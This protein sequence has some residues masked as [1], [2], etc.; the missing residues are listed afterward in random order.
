VTRETVADKS[1][2]YLGEGR[3]VIDRVH[4][5]AIHA[6]CRGEGELYELG[7]LPGRGWWCSCPAR[8]DCC[9]LRA[10]RLVTIRWSA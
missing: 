7:H 10:L 4:G 2:R 3:L 1:R 8:G 5:D 9:H 6:S